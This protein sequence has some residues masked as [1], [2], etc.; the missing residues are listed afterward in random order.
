MNILFFTRLFHPH[1]GGVEK[2]VLNLSQQLI[3]RGNKVTILTESLPDTNTKPQEIYQGI[4][5]YRMPYW[6]DGRN[7]KLN[8]WKWIFKNQKLIQQADIVH[9]H[10]VFYWY[11]PFR[12]IYQSKPVYTTFH[13]YES[14][15]ITKRAKIQHQIAEKLSWGNICIGDFIPKWYGTKPTF[16]SYGAVEI[17][18]QIKKA[19]KKYSAVFIGRLDDQTGI[20]E[21][22]ETIIKIRKKIPQFHFTV[23][24]DGSLRENLP[25]NTDYKGFSPNPGQFLDQSHFAFVSRYLSILEA[26]AHKRLVFALYD[27][28]I[29][30]DYLRLAPYASNIIICSSAEELA[31]KVLYYLEHPEKEQELIERSYRWIKNQT[32]ENLTQTYLALW[33]SKNQ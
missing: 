20:T 7:K 28:Q 23:I 14:Y 12:L 15:P 1:I 24:G 31:K 29:K 10:D 5:I 4:T 18:K 22:A 17:S 27:N 13:G 6:E 11:L 16:V 19:K 26:M 25:D 33:Q 30:E 8:T 32:W 21:Y 9:I 2:H 3:L